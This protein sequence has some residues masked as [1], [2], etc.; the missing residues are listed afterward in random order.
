MLPMDD[1]QAIR[2]GLGEGQGTQRQTPRPTLLVDIQ[3][4]NPFNF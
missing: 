2:T 3:E 1:I 4:Q